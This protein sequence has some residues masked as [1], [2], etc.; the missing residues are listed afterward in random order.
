LPEALQMAAQLTAG[1]EAKPPPKLMTSANAERVIADLRQHPRIQPTTVKRLQNH[2]ASLLGKKGDDP[3]V[4]R[5]VEELKYLKVVVL[6]GNKPTY[7]FK[8]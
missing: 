7:H 2:A 4:A 1:T 6:V 3:E 8:K 5:V